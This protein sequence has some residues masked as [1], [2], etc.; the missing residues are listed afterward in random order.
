MVPLSPIFCDFMSAECILFKEKVNEQTIKQSNKPPIREISESFCLWS[1]G[2]NLITATVS[3]PPFSQIPQTGLSLTLEW[4][5]TLL[6]NAAGQE[7]FFLLP[8]EEAAGRET[9]VITQEQTGDVMNELISLRFEDTE[10][11]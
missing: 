11:L 2:S 6:D 8:D 1:L 4:S 10:L 3:R 5:P 7:P 9:R